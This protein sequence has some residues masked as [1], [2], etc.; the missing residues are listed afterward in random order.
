MIVPGAAQGGRR[1]GSQGSCEKRAMA[2]WSG[3][4]PSGLQEW[5]SRQSSWHRVHRGSEEEVLGD[6]RRGSAARRCRRAPAARQDSRPVHE[7]SSRGVFTRSL[8]EESPRRVLRFVL[9]AASAHSPLRARRGLVL[10]VRPPSLRQPRIPRS[11]TWSVRSVRHTES[12]V[13]GPTWESV[14]TVDIPKVLLVDR[15]RNFFWFQT[16]V[17]A[18]FLLSWRWWPRFLRQPSHRS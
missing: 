11:S 18:K 2:A 6:N 14:D 16:S 4:A 5:G 3:W 9:G 1:S 17:F 7:E 12:I 8:H 10:G 15:K 13:S